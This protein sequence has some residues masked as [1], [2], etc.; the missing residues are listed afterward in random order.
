MQEDL[1]MYDNMIHLS[2]KKK[3]FIFILEMQDKNLH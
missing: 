2:I 1:F 3:W